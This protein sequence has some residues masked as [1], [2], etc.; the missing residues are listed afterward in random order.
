MTQCFYVFL[1]CWFSFPFCLKRFFQ[2]GLTGSAWGDWALYTD[3]PLRSGKMSPGY[4][5][6]PEFN[7][8]KTGQSP[9][10]KLYSRLAVY[11]KGEH[12]SLNRLDRIRVDV[13]VT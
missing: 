3:S 12:M 6:L 11:D 2:D 7:K 1:L 4:N 8:P 13:Q 5:T 10:R 9:R